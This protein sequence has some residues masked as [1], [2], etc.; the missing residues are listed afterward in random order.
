MDAGCLLPR[1]VGKYTAHTSFLLIVSLESTL[2]EVKNS[3]FESSPAKDEEPQ[4]EDSLGN[5]EVSRT[6]KP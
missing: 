5:M 3:C 6:R 2:N 1:L 4:K